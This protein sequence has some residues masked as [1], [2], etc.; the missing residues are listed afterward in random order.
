MVQEVLSVPEVT[1][2]HC[3]SAIEGAVGALAGVSSV[4]VDLDRKDVTIAYDAAAV[5]H[6]SIVTAIQGEGYEV[7]GVA[8]G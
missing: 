4:K 1:C 6:D 3:V 7:A 5:G 8:A 2:H